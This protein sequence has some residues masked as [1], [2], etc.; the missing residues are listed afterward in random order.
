M[1][2]PLTD[3]ERTA[4]QTSLEALNR[5]VGQYPVSASRRVTNMDRTGYV[6]TKCLC[7]AVE[8]KLVD[9]LADA[10][11]AGMTVDELADASGAHPDRLQQVLRVL[12]ND[13]IFDY[14]AVS[15]RY[16][17]NRV[18]ALLHSGH[19]TQWH[20]WVDLYGN[21]FY[22]IARGIPRSIR[23]EE[24]RWAAQINFDT[25]DDMFTYFQAQGWL[26]RLHRTLGGGAIAQAPGIVADYPWHEIGSRTVL[27]VGGG[28]G[29]FLASLLREYP[30]MRG[31]ILDLPRPYFDLRERVPRENLIAGDFLKAVPAFEI[32]TMKWVLHD[33]KDPDVLTILRCI[34]ASL[35]PGPDSRLVILESNLSD[36]QMGRLSRYGDINMMMTANGQERSEEQWRALAA[37]SGWEVSRIYP[38][39]R[40]WMS[41]NTISSDPNGAVVM[42]DMEYDGRV[43]L[44]IIKADETSYI[45]YIKPLILAEE[46][47][48]PHVLSVID[49]RDEWFYSIHPERMVPS[50]KD[51]DPVTGEKVIVFEST[52]C[53]QYLVDR[54]DTDGTWSGRTV[55]EKGA[56]LSWTAYQTA[57]LGPTAKYWLYFKRGYPTRANPVQLPRTIEKLHANTLRQWDILEKRLKEPGQQYIAL[58]DRPTLADLSY[59]P[60]A[61][62]WMFTF[63]GVDIKDWPHIQRWSE[64]MLSRPAVARVLQRAPTLGH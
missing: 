16:R 34:R 37:A 56:I 32:Y 35:I 45:N 52:A 33:W 38:M 11:E 44:Y 22:D 17:N 43:I 9:I 4:L 10:D 2:A 59:F 5:Q 46:I 24:A 60:F 42:G 6:S 27:D 31:G 30:Q 54:F 55:A 63:L 14:D 64:R 20:N 19:W 29:G 40:A 23:R 49:T 28:G 53:L 58:K 8:L 7:A 50:L 57:A 25:H 13:N 39:R 1:D 18:S 61:M 26:P 62:P 47:Q 51:Q 12:R 15:H 21:E 48:F 41:S 36:G 3:V